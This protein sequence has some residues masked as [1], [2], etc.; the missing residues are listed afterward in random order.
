MS[1]P[2]ASAA[3]PSVAMLGMGLIGRP[4]GR[5]LH[6]A[7]FPLRCWNRSPLDPALAEGLPPLSA[8]PAEAL[9][10]ADVVLVTTPTAFHLEPAL[11]AVRA[12]LLRELGR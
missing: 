12:E 9:A 2:P 5:R 8:T 4:A 6:A 3:L 1:T 10:G 7:G 11:A